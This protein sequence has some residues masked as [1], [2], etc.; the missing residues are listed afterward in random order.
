MHTMRILIL[1]L[2]AP[3]AVPAAAEPAAMTFWRA[4][5]ARPLAA[6]AP[7]GDPVTAEKIALGGRLFNDP[8][9]SGGGERTCASCHQANR[10]FA[11]GLPRARALT[12]EPLPR[13]TP[14]LWN[15]AWSP[16]LHWDGI[17]TSLETQA[18]RPIE[19]PRELAGSWPA[20]VAS[21]ER[22][23]GIAALFAR[24]FPESPLVSMDTITR[25]LA[26]FERSLVSPPT[27]FDRWV[28]GGGA[29][30][31]DEIAGFE[32]FTGKAGCVGCHAGWRFTD[33]AFHDTG[34]PGGD[35]GQGAV[36]GGVPGLAAF[37]TPSLR[38]AKWSAPYMHDGSLATLQ[39][40]VDHYTDGIAA[41]PGLSSKL[42]RPLVLSAEEKARLVAFLGALSS[43]APPEAPE[44]AWGS[45]ERASHLP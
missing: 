11:D 7:P 22:D 8:R 4:F 31:A 12:G 27:R 35:P 19:H 18:R 14:S 28:A 42:T 10:S 45:K 15:V 1:L 33:D 13:N 17:V 34:L 23:T 2:L 36:P 32:L 9:L 5:F 29:L 40:A 38:E 43:G 37:K 25:A 39:A 21:L 26:A 44:G 30:A 41:R 3:L 16:V 6:P 20:I 24:A